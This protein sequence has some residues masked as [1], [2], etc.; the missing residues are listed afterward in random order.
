M[1]PPRQV[2]HSLPGPPS[3]NGSDSDAN[4]W[5]E[6]LAPL[7]AVEIK[8]TP[9]K[10]AVG[11]SRLMKAHPVEANDCSAAARRRGGGARECES[12]GDHPRLT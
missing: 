12:L 1:P 7:S 11:T 5:R 8:Q 2:E 4:V 9:S 6:K 10:I 3:N